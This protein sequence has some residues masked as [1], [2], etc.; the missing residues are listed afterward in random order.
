MSAI[1]AAYTSIG[2][3]REWYVLRLQPESMEI[4]AGP[5]R[6]Q[7]SAALTCNIKAVLEDRHAQWGT[8]PPEICRG[9]TLNDM[10]YSGKGW[11]IHGR[12]K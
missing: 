4:V 3:F 12:E 2:N 10:P 9:K 11:L 8:I 6:G 1:I 7:M 5:F